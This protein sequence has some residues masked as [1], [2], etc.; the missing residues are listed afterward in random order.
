[1]TWW[2]SLTFNHFAFFAQQFIIFCHHRQRRPVIIFVALFIAKQRAPSGFRQK[3]RFSDK[4]AFG[5]IQLNNALP[6][7]RICAKLHQILT[8]NQVVNFRFVVI[9]IDARTAR[10][11]NDG[12]VRIH[13]FVVP[14]AISRIGIDR[15]LREQIRCMDAN[16]VQYRMTSGKVLFRQITAI[17]TRIGN[18]LMGFIQ[19]LADIQNVLRT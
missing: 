1:M 12:V 2:L 11:R 3:T 14:T 7:Y 10:G 5:N 13:F 15:R 9:Q 17:R 16:R 4:L 6:E 19:L 18:Q 8:G